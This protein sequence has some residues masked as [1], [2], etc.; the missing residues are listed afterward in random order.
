M[1]WD[2]KVSADLAKPEE[3]QCPIEEQSNPNVTEQ[4]VINQRGQ[5]KPLTWQKYLLYIGKYCLWIYLIM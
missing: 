2:L 3:K 5:E 4:E 1:A